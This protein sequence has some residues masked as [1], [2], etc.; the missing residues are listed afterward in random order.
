MWKI[1][2]A[3]A[4]A[5]PSQWLIL[6]AMLRSHRLCWWTSSIRISWVAI[7]GYVWMVKVKNPSWKLT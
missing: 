3:E 4:F 5:P 6:F 2:I 7:Y 1:T